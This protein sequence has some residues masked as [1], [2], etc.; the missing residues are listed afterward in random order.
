MAVWALAQKA[1]LR[2]L[3]MAPRADDAAARIEEDDVDGKAHAEGVDG[4]AAG[5]GEGPAL[6]RLAP[7]SESE[8]PVLRAGWP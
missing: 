5:E 1:I 2:G 6:G 3:S 7:E 4:A 8:E